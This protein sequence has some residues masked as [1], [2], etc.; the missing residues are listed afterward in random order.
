LSTVNEGH[1][2]SVCVPT[3]DMTSPP[4]TGAIYI[5]SND[6]S[7]THTIMLTAEQLSSIASGQSVVVTSTSDVDPKTK[8]AHTHDWMITKAT[9]TTTTPPPSGW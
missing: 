6:G 2:H 1:T 3:S 7:H 5:S 4:A 9:S 8:V